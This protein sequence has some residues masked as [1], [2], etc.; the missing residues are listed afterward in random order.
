MPTFNFTYP[1]PDELYVENWSQGLTGTL[2]YDGPAEVNLWF[3]ED[4]KTLQTSDWDVEEGETEPKHVDSLKKVTVNAADGD[5]AKT[6]LWFAKLRSPKAEMGASEYPEEIRESVTSDGKNYER[7]TNPRP[8]HL[9][10]LVLNTSGSDTPTILIEHILKF[11]ETHAEHIC[12]VRRAKVKHFADQYDL[13]AEAEAAALTFDSACAAYLEAMAD[14]HQWMYIEQP[15]TSIPK[16]PLSVASAIATIVGA[17]GN[18][19]VEPG[20]MQWE[21]TTKFWTE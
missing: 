20:I 15:L 8:D 6:I 19:F 4:S 5:R 3:N 21:P 9:F 1:V 17:V 13:G 14:N 7:I 10:Q 18:D 16:I 2:V 12:K 11:P